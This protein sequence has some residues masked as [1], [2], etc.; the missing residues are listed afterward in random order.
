M[1]QLIGQSILIAIKVLGGLSLFLYGM[2]MMGDGLDKT[3][4]M[5]M[6]QIIE[7]L[8]GNIFKGIIVGTLVTGVIQSSSA[9][10]VMV[11]GFVSAGVMTLRQASGI[12]MGAN[13]GT[14]VTAHIL[15]LGDISDSDPFLSLVKPDNLMYI[16]LIIGMALIFLARNQTKKDSGEIF[17]G[18]ALIFAG[19]N[20][21]TGGL[22]GIDQGFF[23]HLFKSFANTPIIGVLVGAVVTGIIQSSS[24]SVGILQA[25]A[26]TG[27][28]TLGGA[29][30][31]ILGQNIGTCATALISSIGATRT[32]KKAAI[33]HLLFNII[34]TILFLIAIYA[35]LPFVVKGWAVLMSGIVNKGSIA[36]FHSIF[37]ITTTLILAP[38]AGFLIYL[39]NLI[40]KDNKAEEVT[41]N[42]KLDERF[43]HSPAIAIGQAKDVVENML[44]LSIKNIKL[45]QDAI[46]NGNMEVI[47]EVKSIE[48]SVDALESNL[49]NYLVRIADK[50]LSE[51][52][53]KMAMGL[54]HVISDIER[55]SD[56]AKNIVQI[57]ELNYKTDI[58]FTIDGNTELK[59]MFLAIFDIL[60]TTYDSLKQ[61]DAKLAGTIEPKEQVIDLFKQ[62]F[63][64]KHLA[65]L[66]NKQCS[67]ES[68]VA[69]LEMTNNLER[70][71]DHCSNI[72]VT[73]LQIHST[74][75]LFNPHE[76]LK[77][78]RKFQSEE[79]QKTYN[80]FLNKY[81][82]PVV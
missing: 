57:A 50:D 45:S 8:T 39:V 61:N 49:G 35:V 5:R 12:I 38:F 40:L 51:S 46:L 67:V 41:I 68:G 43:L 25:V 20:F 48:K 71:A 64:I 30:P 66:K 63:K 79:Y 15:R 4:G 53:S 33:F 42:N 74:D 16:L 78:E 56:H 81:Y 55:I 32:A 14:T 26:G 36:D 9:T 60:D 24:A 17:V 28:I 54:M 3:A 37:N 62:T 2:K 47:S 65:R 52:E 69:F 13:I 70:V 77:H 59:N 76:Y 10:T 18:L 44:E 6:Q 58:K 1:D 11:V 31:I 72:G 82:T 34:G 22:K 27:T 73:I 19:M 7:S 75:A 80:D 21:M 23:E 29:I